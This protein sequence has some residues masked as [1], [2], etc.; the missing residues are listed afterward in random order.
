MMKRLIQTAVLLAL[1]LHSTKPLSAE[2]TGRF[3]ICSG[4]T[5]TITDGQNEERS[6]ILKIDT[7]TGETWELWDVSLPRAATATG[8]G[9]RVIGWMPIY[10]DV[11]KGIEAAK[12]ARL[13]TNSIAPSIGDQIVAA[14]LGRTNTPS[15]KLGR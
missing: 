4:K 10:S 5:Q 2:E 3:Q 13:A 1:A 12:T 11:M 14:S 7:Q 15:G 6:Y 9:A 8:L